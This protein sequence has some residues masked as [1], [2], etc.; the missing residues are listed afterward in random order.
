[1]VVD[2]APVLPQL[3]KLPAALLALPLQVLLDAALLPVRGL[4]H[5]PPEQS[6]LVELL[7]THVTPAGDHQT[8]G[9]LPHQSSICHVPIVFDC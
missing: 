1:M 2:V 6:L 3:G 7:P 9:S 5:V 4:L 8:G